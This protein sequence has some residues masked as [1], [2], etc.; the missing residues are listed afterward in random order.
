MDREVI[1]KCLAPPLLNRSIRVALVVGTLL[2][3]INQGD[4]I[5]AGESPVLWKV[6]LTFLVPFMVA[7][8]GAYSALACA[9][10]A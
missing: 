10:D 5:L 4:V 7:S 2:T 3:A 6:A 9:Q 1:L 8:F